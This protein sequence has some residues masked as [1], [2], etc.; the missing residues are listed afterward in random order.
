MDKWNISPFNFKSLPLTQVRDEWVKYKRNFQYI[1]LANG[2]TDQTKL[3]YIFLAKAGP[4]VQEVFSSLR[5]ADVAEDVDK[6]IK[7]FDVAIC[8]FDAYFAPR[9]HETFERHIFWTL[10]PNTEESLEKFLLRANEQAAKC[11]FGTSKEESVEISVIDKLILL[12]PSDLKEQLLQK[13][14]LTLD[15]LTKMINSYSSVKYQASQMTPHEVFSTTSVINKVQ[16]YPL[17]E[18]SECSRCGW[19]GHYASDPKCPA[20]NKICDKCKKWAISPNVVGVCWET[21]IQVTYKQRNKND[22]E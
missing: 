12:A 3:K 22:V 5:D 6:T 14:K 7:P 4:D 19:N 17:R 18:Q 15:E 13:E 20:K 11:N 21:N 2:E 9:H 8:K 16:A 1:A 10:K